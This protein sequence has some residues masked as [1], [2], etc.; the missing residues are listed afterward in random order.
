MKPIKLMELF[1]TFVCYKFSHYSNKKLWYHIQTTN[2][3]PFQFTIPIEE[4]DGA[5]IKDIETSKTLL[6][7]WVKKEV[8]FY[9]ENFVE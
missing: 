2:A 7:K 5:L 4:L 6:M 8:D 1:N 9:N 3:A